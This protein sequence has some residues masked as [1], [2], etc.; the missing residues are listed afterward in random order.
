MKQYS[1]MP[2]FLLLWSFAV[3]LFMSNL[4]AIYVISSMK[5]FQSFKLIFLEITLIFF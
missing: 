1:V 5:S 4:T 3:T 2:T